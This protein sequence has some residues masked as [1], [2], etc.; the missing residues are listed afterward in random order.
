MIEP[1]IGTTV[2][3]LRPGDRVRLISPA[4][5]P[6]PA[7]VAR[8]VKVVEGWGLEVDLGKHVFERLAFLA[9]TDEHRAADLNEALRYPAIRGIFTTRGGWVADRIGDKT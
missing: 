2:P 1:T 7:S 9:G 4:S 6:D 5:P 8:F 3:L